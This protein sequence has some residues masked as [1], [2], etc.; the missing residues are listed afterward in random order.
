MS[1]AGPGWSET[2][3]EIAYEEARQLIDTQHQTVSEI[4]ETAMRTVRLTAVLIGLMIAAIQVDAAAIHR[5]SLGIAGLLLILS[6][7][8]GIGTYDESNLYDG[9]DGAYIEMVADGQS[10]DDWEYDLVCTYAGMATEN[11]DLIS[12]NASMLRLT[13]VLFIAGVVGLALAVLI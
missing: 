1:M 2:R 5:E 3:R 11:A 7:I 6:V 9:P 8:A 10:V 13:N 12:R 4:D